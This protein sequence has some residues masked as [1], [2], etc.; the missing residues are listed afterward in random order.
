MS[1]LKHINK[2]L[3]QLSPHATSSKDISRKLESVRRQ[4]ENKVCVCV[5]VSCVV[6]EIV[7]IWAYVSVCVCMCMYV[8]VYVGVTLCVYMCVCTCVCVTLTY[9]KD[10]DATLDPWAC[11]VAGGDL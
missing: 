5:C 9:F 10:G 1:A 7:C 6:C 2:I 11:P 8:G 4:K 3:A